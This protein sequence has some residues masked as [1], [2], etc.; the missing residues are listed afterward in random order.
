MAAVVPEGIPPSAE[1]VVYALTLPELVQRLEAAGIPLSA[2]VTEAAMRCALQGFMEKRHK[3]ATP[4]AVFKEFDAD[5]SGGLDKQE[6]SM[7]CATLGNLLGA[8]ALDDLFAELDADGDGTVSIDEFTS[9]WETDVAPNMSINEDAVARASPRARGTKTDSEVDSLSIEDLAKRLDEVDI[10]IPAGVTL[11]AMRCALKGHID[12]RAET[13][14]C[15]EVFKEFDMDNSN[16]L[17]KLELTMVCATLGNLLGAEGLDEL[18][19]ELDSDGDGTVSIEE[20]ADWWE[21]DVVRCRHSLAT[22]T[23]AVHVP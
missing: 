13:A 12:K 22:F 7:V 15:A 1:A 19:D 14:T 2:G 4:A 17:D 5:M 3:T 8:E 9:W 6:L 20:F 21:R 11:A 18:F 10:A 16:S 23:V